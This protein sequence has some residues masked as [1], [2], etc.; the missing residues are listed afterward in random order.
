MKKKASVTKTVNDVENVASYGEIKLGSPVLPGGN[1]KAI[2]VGN[3][4]YVCVNG[5]WEGMQNNSIRE[6]WTRVSSTPITLT[7]DNQP[8]Q[9]AD[10]C[11]DIKF[12]NRFQFRS[13]DYTPFPQTSHLQ[14]VASPT[15]TPQTAW[16]YVWLKSANTNTWITPYQQQFQYVVANITTCGD[17]D[18]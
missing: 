8:V 18:T 1:T 5:V 3:A 7:A 17:H 9:P 13:Y 10:K 16:V 12:D 15:V 11:V 2:K 4:G 14:E 6:V